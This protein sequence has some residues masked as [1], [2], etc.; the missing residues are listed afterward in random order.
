VAGIGMGG[1]GSGWASR[2]EMGVAVGMARARSEWA[3]AI[4][5]GV[6]V[7]NEGF[8]ETLYFERTV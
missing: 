6:A 3:I 5:M 8:A 2:S 7:G 4:G 1:R